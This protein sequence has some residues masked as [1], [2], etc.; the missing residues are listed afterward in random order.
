[1]A[2]NFAALYHEYGEEMQEL[3]DAEFGR[4]CR[5]LLAYSKDGTP[6]ALSGNE[7]FFAK[8]V[9]A[10]EDRVIAN[11]Q[12][13][14]D[15]GRQAAQTRWA[16]QSHT[17]AYERIRTDATECETMRSDASDANSKSIS[18][19]ISISSKE[20]KEKISSKEDTK[21]KVFVAPS[22]DE[23]KAE[24]DAK[25]YTFGFDAWFAYYE[26]NGW[27]VGNRKMRDWKA[28][29][30]YWQS[31]EKPKPNSVIP[32]LNYGDTSAKMARMRTLTQH[33]TEGQT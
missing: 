24:Y 17:N 15:A 20:D 11:Y 21:K 29:M 26:Q 13:R 19:S 14:V 2:R 32:S 33:L 23:A 25:G 16:M 5:A 7:R 30:R 31:K 18:K 12:A 1:M 3:S 22:E 4:L 9:M 27:M 28:S 10:Q 6:I 8:R